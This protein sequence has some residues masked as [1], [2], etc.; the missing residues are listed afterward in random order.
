M[1][2][3]LKDCDGPQAG[4]DGKNFPLV[5]RVSADFLCFWEVVDFGV[6]LRHRKG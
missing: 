2:V 5:A 6:F 1:M 4:H 3:L